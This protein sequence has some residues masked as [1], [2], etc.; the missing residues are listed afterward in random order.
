MTFKISPEPNPS[1]ST[2]G[3]IV[4]FKEAA[5]VLAIADFAS[6]SIGGGYKRELGPRVG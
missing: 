3:S 1:D 5:D 6:R 2:T 4:K